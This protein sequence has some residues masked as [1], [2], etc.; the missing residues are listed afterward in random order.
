MLDSGLPLAGGLHLGG[1]T[2]IM[3]DARLAHSLQ[4][5]STRE[6][7]VL[8]QIVDGLGPVQFAPILFISPHT[9]KTHVKNIRH[10]LGAHS[11]LEIAS[12]AVRS[13]MLPTPPPTIR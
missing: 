9:A 11:V 2:P 4:T 5:L 6:L 3:H 12:I 7:E 13:G 8:Q 1:R 10:K